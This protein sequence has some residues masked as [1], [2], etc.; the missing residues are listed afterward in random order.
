MLIIYLFLSGGKCGKIGYWM[1]G[2][3]EGIFFV[4]FRIF[5]VGI[6]VGGVVTSICLWQWY[7][8]K[9]P[10]WSPIRE[11]ATPAGTYIYSAYANNYRH[12]ATPHHS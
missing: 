3:M 1:L 7:A 2:G 11:L 12:Y 5:L 6:C 4:Y 8:A 9:N 10:G